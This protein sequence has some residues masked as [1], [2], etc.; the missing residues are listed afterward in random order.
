M[1][2]HVHVNHF[3]SEDHAAMPSHVSSRDRWNQ[4]ALR[5]GGAKNLNV[6]MRI[7]SEECAAC[8]AKSMWEVCVL[9]WHYG[10]VRQNLGMFLAVSLGNDGNKKAYM[11]VRHEHTV[12]V[13]LSRIH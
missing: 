1:S 5:F 12:F 2:S 13:F 10:C 8:R 11:H 7:R 9:V 6:I 3:A 4:S